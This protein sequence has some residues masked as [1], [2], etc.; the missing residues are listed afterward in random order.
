MIYFG[1]KIEGIRKPHYYIVLL[2]LYMVAVNI[3]G[4]VIKAIASML[5]TCQN[6]S[7]SLFP[8]IVTWLS[9]QGKELKPSFILMFAL[10]PCWQPPCSH[11]SVIDFHLQPGAWSDRSTSFIWRKSKFLNITNKD[12]IINGEKTLIINYEI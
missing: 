7:S 11:T 10:P 5:M 8:Q 9:E 12:K 4:C 2:I 6:H 3:K 1:G